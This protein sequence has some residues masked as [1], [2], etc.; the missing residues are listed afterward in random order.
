[1]QE[2]RRKAVLEPLLPREALQYDYERRER[3]LS[4]AR[5]RANR[6]LNEARRVEAQIDRI[7]EGCEEYERR[8]SH[9]K[10][11]SLALEQDF[12]AQWRSLCGT[13][14]EEEQKRSDLDHGFRQR[15]QRDQERFGEDES[16]RRLFH[17]ALEL[18]EGRGQG[19]A[20]SGV[21]YTLFEQLGHNIESAKRLIV[22]LNTE[23]GTLERKRRDLEQQFYLQGE[24][25]DTNL[26]R[27]AESS[28]V[29]LEG[30][31]TAIPMVQINLPEEV[32][33]QVAR[34]R[35]TQELSRGLE[36]LLERMKGEQTTHVELN[37]AVRAL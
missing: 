34:S 20:E 8:F 28:K 37:N 6:E 11:G 25:L 4:E 21:Y 26:K 35:I 27:L 24:M 33:P 17:S 13:W 32:D 15:L 10:P 14:K 31:K 2:E 1:V 9:A 29:R 3:A 16:F 12:S 19:V 5:T 30:R 23:L 36:E 7:W 22:Q 18:L